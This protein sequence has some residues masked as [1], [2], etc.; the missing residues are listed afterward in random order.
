MNFASR[1]MEILRENQILKSRLRTAK[2][3][4]RN[5]KRDVKRSQISE[6]DETEIDL[7]AALAEADI[8]E[9]FEIDLAEQFQLSKASLD[10]HLT[11][12]IKTGCVNILFEDPAFGENFAITQKGRQ[13][14]FNR[15]LL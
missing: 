3:Q 15:N 11:K 12:L 5:L 13:V 7:L 1:Q 4:I 9:S 6:L 8:N 2:N 14:L 10:F